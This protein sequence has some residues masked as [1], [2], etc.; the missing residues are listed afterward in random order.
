M[1]RRVVSAAVTGL[2]L[3]APIACG[4]DSGSSDGPVGGPAGTESAQNPTNPLLPPLDT[5][6]PLPPNDLSF[7]R[8]IY[9]PYLESM[10]LRISYGKLQDPKDGYRESPNGTHLALYAIPTGDYTPDQYVADIW[11]ITATMTPDVFARWSGLETWDICQLPAGIEVDPSDPP[12]GVTQIALSREQASRI[13]W[14]NGDLVDLLVAK[15]NDRKILINVSSAIRSN[16]SYKAAD[17]A[18]RSRAEAA[19]TTLG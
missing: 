16:P 10:G 5:S 9:D 3:L 13:D 2:L 15:R 6:Q 1:T 7:F 8:S 12:A 19:G 14:A 18:A 4:E 17:D 11:T